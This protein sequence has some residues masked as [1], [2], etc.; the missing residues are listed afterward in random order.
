MSAT[1]N[2][3]AKTSVA[4]F[5]ELGISE[6]MF[7]KDFT[8]R[9]VAMDASGCWYVFDGH[10]T[11]ESG[12]WRIRNGYWMELRINGIDGGLHLPECATGVS[13]EDSLIEI[14]EAT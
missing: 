1:E 5:A 11:Y 10:P 14:S 6:I 9:Y 12:E 7:P 3:L 8:A 4:T 2:Q 13:A